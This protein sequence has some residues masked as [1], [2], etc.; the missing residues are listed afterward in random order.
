MHKHVFKRDSEED[1]ELASLISSERVFQRVRGLTEKN[2]INL[3]PQSGLKL[4][5]LNRL[6][7]TDAFVF[8]K[9]TK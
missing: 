4:H 3:G 7:L 6:V 1:K 5:R 8:L 9:G 2:L